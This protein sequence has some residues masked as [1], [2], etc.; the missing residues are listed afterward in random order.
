MNDY[1]GFD[2][3]ANQPEPPEFEEDTE[4][5]AHLEATAP[6]EI[7]ND[8]M[9]DYTRAWEL[10]SKSRSNENNN[11]KVIKNFTITPQTSAQWLDFIETESGTI[12]RRGKGISSVLVEL[13][14]QL[15]MA[16]IAEFNVKLVAKNLNA[17]MTDNNKRKI[18]IRNLERL[19]EY[20]SIS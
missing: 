9:I 14:M 13:S 17:I 5:A 16:T 18:V 3:E 15:L 10:F 2:T 4:Y 12:P 19:I 1:P 11:K 6:N 20:L 8:R 7:G